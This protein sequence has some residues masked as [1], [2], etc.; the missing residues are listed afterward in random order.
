MS[1]EVMGT[2]FLDGAQ[3]RVPDALQRAFRAR[4]RT[5]FARCDQIILAEDLSSTDVFLINAGK[6]RISLLSRQ[7]RETILREMGEGEIFGELAAIDRQARS[8]RVIALQDTTLSHLT[9]DEFIAFLGDTP[10]AGL[11]M[12]RQLSTRIRDLTERIFEL[13]TMPVG[14]RLH[15][16]LLRLGVPMGEDGETAVI[17]HFPT[18]ADLASRIGTHREAI[19]RELGLLAKDGILR[20]TGR[21]MQ[22]LSV[23]RLRAM[24]L[25]FVH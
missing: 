9:G 20:Q 2:E 21:R 13:T 1:A 25:R 10:A 3:E 14:S 23:G 19:T 17:D 6:V 18:H 8:A 5:I 24:L 12:T 7:G 11:W 16:E 4:A 15:R 22:V